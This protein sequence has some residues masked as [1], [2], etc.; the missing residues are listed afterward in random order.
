MTKE[1]IRTISLAKLNLKGAK[2]FLDVGTGTGSIA[3]E[4]ALH[5]PK[6]QV[7][8]I[9]SNPEA[10]AL[11]EANQKKLGIDSINCVLGKAPIV[12]EST[13]DA[14]F[15]GGSGG[16]IRKILEWALNHLK[17]D[18]RLVLNF[19]LIDNAKEAIDCLEENNCLFDACQ[20]QVG[21]YQRLGKGHFYKPI[22]PVI[23]IEARKEENK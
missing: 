23:I 15:V 18:G 13:F 12:L 20:V 5:Y 21:R 16:N 17:M 3:L 4:A 6:L 2:T 19:I 11:V 9:D 22:N 1:E 7:T 8:A 10:L 14:I